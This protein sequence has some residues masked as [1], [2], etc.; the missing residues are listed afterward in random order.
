M[1]TQ[2]I[3]PTSTKTET[4]PGCHALTAEQ[5]ASFENN[6]FFV[7]RGALSDAEIERYLAIVDR[8]DQEIASHV[9]GAR[10]PGEALELRNAVEFDQSIV[11]LMTHRSAFPQILDLMGPAIGL[12]TSHMLIRPPSPAVKREEKVVGWHRDGP[13]PR[14]LAV[15]GIEPWL[16]TKIGYFLTDTMIPDAG[17]LSVVP[18]SHRYGGTPPQVTGEVNP[19]GTYEVTMKPGDAVIFENR[20]LHAVGPNYSAISRKNFYFGYCWRYLRPIDFTTQPESVLAWGDKYQRQLMGE[21]ASAL[22][23]YLPG[24]T[25]N[26][27]ADWK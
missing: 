4:L 1:I 21:A 3:E 9:K 24:Q 22:E 2:A 12:T 25:H 6:G 17:A 15:N 7:I 26:P 18:G 20:V 16:Y 19:S 14:P 10:Q 23:F 11:E 27:L 5:K 13:N 8:G